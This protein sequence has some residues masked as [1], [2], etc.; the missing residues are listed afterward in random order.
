MPVK[1]TTTT[2]VTEYDEEERIVKT[3]ET[4]VEEVEYPEC[5]NVQDPYPHQHPNIKIRSRG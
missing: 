1:K 2:K 4:I 3:T 5:V